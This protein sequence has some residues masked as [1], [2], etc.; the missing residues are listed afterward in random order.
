ME[1][2]DA[3]CGVKDKVGAFLFFVISRIMRTNF[4]VVIYRGL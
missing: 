4:Q 1:A 2:G 3:S